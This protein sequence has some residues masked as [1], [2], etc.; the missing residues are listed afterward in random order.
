MIKYDLLYILKERWIDF[1]CL[2]IEWA[3]S[4]FECLTVVAR[5]NQVKKPYSG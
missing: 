5:S 4:A 2:C 1:F 3:L